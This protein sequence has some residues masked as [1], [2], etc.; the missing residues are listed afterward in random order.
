MG[1]RGAGVTAGIP[2]Q[3]DER[4]TR[5]TVTTATAQQAVPAEGLRPQENA[6]LGCFKER[7]IDECRIR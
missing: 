3:V 6:R 2:I 5:Q 1:N 4:P 7:K